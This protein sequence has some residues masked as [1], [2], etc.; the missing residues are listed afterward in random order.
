MLFG[1]RV[2]DRLE[3]DANFSPWKARISL[4]LEENKLWDIFHGTTA[5][6]IVIHAHATDKKTFMK[7]GCEGKKG[8]S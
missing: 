7:K 1:L 8:H 6:P 4:I 2:E 5:K 3:G